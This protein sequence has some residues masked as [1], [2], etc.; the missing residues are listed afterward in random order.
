MFGGLFGKSGPQLKKMAPKHLAQVIQIIEETDEDDAAEAEETL[1]ERNLQGMYVLLNEGRVLGVTG[2][3]ATE[4][5]DDVNW[6]SWTYLSEDSRGQ[7]LGRFMVN[8]LLGTLNA[9]KIRKIFIATSDYREDGEDIY[10]DA[11][12]LYEGFGAVEELRIT[13]F[14]SNDEAKII[15]GLVNPGVEAMPAGA[16]ERVTG[17]EFHDLYPAPES[18]GGFGIN[19]T[20]A[21]EGVSGLD[22]LVEEAGRESARMVVTSL[23]QDVSEY[24]E[25]DLI[26]HGFEKQGELKDYYGVGISQIWWAHTGNDIKL[27]AH[28]PGSAGV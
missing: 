5:V 11:R 24:A 13:K 17:V 4:D 8:E 25:N 28:S 2:A 14:H 3:V 9:R 6:L 7:G 26:Q 23:P 16:F 22:V 18:S 12:R 27:I 1:V 19:W 15:Y 10:A 20:V 21:E